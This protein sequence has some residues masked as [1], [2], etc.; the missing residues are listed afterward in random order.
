MA[1][2]ED[3]LA[4]FHKMID[5]GL[6]K[7]YDRF[8]SLQS[9][10]ETHGA[11]VSTEDANQKFIRSLPSSCTQIMAFVSSDNTS[12]TNEVNIAFG[13]S[14]SSGHNSQTKGSSS[15]TDD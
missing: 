6:H 12:S 11:G 9:Q 3:H 2:P 13:V 5:E 15:Y 8:Q 10:L 1:I 7:G 4:K 14:T